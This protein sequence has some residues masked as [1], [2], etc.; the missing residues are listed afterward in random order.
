VV[1]VPFGETPLGGARI[2]ELRELVQLIARQ[3]LKGSVEVR[4]HSGRYCLSGSSRDGYSLAETAVPYRQCDLM[5]D[6]TDPALGPAPQESMEF[7]ATLA[8]IRRQYGNAIRIEVTV[9][10]DTELQQAYPEIRGDPP[11]V[12]TAGEWNAAA[13]ANNRVDLRWH[14]S[15]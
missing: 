14:P 3:G 12:P 13:E 9:G 1:H 8:E 2:T 6:P 7:A 5:A 4:R 15:T 10:N 11:R